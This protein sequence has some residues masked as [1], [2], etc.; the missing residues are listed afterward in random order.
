MRPDVDGPPYYIYG[1]RVEIAG[2]LVAM[3]KLVD[4]QGKKYPVVALIL[5]TDEPVVNSLVTWDLTIVIATLTDK[6]WYTDRRYIEKIKPVL[7]PL[8]EKFLVELK[9]SGLFVWPGNQKYPPHTRTVRPYWGTSTENKNER[10]ILDDPLDAIE[11]T[12]L[13]INS[14][15]KPCN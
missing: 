6:T 9:Q 3:D 4:K 2:R 14:T 8:Y 11:I 1:R 15:N 12:N 5:D 13:K 10:L 7:V